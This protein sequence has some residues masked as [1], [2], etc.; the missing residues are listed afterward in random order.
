M[1]DGLFN[2]FGWWLRIDA[3][4]G[5]HVNVF[6]GST[7]G[8][9]DVLDTLTGSATYNGQAAGK[10][11]INPQLP[12][13][14]LMGGA[15]T[16]DATLTANFDAEDGID[17]TDENGMLSGMIDNI[18][19]EGEETDWTVALGGSRITT[20]VDAGGTDV[21]QAQVTLTT[22]VGADAVDNGAGKVTW[23]IGGVGSSRNGDWSAS[24]W[25]ANSTDTTP[26]S[27]TGTFTATYNSTV[28]KM[29]GAFGA[30]RE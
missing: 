4:G 17:D 6:H 9:A 7:E 29:E 24:F 3:N 23:S 14:E 12:D 8:H 20:V 2:H 18:M 28:G 10:V 30:N 13:R 19:V 5:Y 22:G 15:F 26:D 1:P 11:S 25:N 21:D 16:G 27:V